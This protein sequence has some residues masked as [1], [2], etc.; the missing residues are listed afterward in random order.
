[1]SH[2]AP[3]TVT[4]KVLPTEITVRTYTLI[5]VHKF[6]ERIPHSFIHTTGFSF[7]L[8]QIQCVLLLSE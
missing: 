4:D 5:K 6:C 2:F 1:M 8:L 7:Y 3:N